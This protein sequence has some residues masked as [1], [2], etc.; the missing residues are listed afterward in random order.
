MKAFLVYPFLLLIISSCNGKGNTRKTISLE[1]VWEVA[2]TMDTLPPK[3]FF[4]KIQVPGL[5]DMSKPGFDSVGYVLDTPESSNYRLK[6]RKSLKRNYFWYRK[7][8]KTGLEKSDFA[9]LKVHKAFY[10]HSVYVNGHFVGN[11]YLCFTPSH[12]EISKYLNYNS[13]NEILIRVGATP[14]ELPDSIPYGRDFE[15]AIYY[16]GLYDRVELYTAD[17]PYIRNIQIVPDIHN[18]KIGV[19]ARIDN[20]KTAKNFKLAY[21]IRE[22]KSQQIVAEGNTEQIQL[23]ENGKIEFNFS[24]KISGCKLWSP[25]KT[26]LYELELCTP[27]DS[28]KVTFG[29]REFRI[30]S[31]TNQAMLNDK[32]YHLRGTNV[33]MHRFFEDTARNYLPW[34]RKWIE[35]MHD[36]FKDMNWNSYR[37]H[38][39]FAPEAWYEVADEKGFLIQDEYAIWGFNMDGGHGFLDPNQHKASV[40][41]KEYKRWMEERWN[42]P[43]VVIWDACNETT[44]KVT[45]EIIDKIRHLDLSDRPWDNGYNE[46]RTPADVRESHPYLLA[47]GESNTDLIWT[48]PQTDRPKGGVL[49]REFSYNPEPLTIP[50]NPKIKTPVI[51][52]EFGWIWLYRDGS[53]GTVAKPI[54]DAYPEMDTEQKRWDMR[55]RFI[56]A[57]T[58]YWRSKREIIGVMHFCAL[59]C[60]RPWGIRP[61][62]VSDEWKDLKNLIMQPGFKK[63]VRPAFSPLGVIIKKWDNVYS[64]GE[65]IEVPVVL[66]ND[67]SENWNGEVTFKILKGGITIYSESKE[68]Q[69]NSAGK[70]ELVFRLAL[71]EKK[72]DYEMIAEI[73][74]NHEIFSTRLFSI[75]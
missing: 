32:L 54:W 28:K 51:V 48:G 3:E 16:P 20:G 37:F 42:H 11:E 6:G 31:K 71:P 60:N 34:D 44:Y 14:E 63:Y 70:S 58:E 2:E 64:H 17:Y 57:M 29:M 23:L 72:D 50:I 38:V 19:V 66:I 13:D 73:K 22:K 45:C 8:I 25:E 27:G 33:A 10:G 49:K 59:T 12:F 75:K 56:A 68:S 41:T 46:P 74:S 4:N 40:L 43:S 7:V 67:L 35:R 21:V 36:E 1:G 15:K 53:T 24:A 30:D 55:G 62:Q 18:E 69:I 5:L 39:G 47:W 65:K 26:F 52:N 61:S 9:Y